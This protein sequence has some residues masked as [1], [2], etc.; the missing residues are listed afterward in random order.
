MEESNAALE[1][2]RS[3]LESLRTE[4]LEGA[5]AVPHTSPVP[6]TAPGPAADKLQARIAAL[7]REN[8]TQRDQF[9][10][11]IGE[12]EALV[13]ARIFKEEELE[14]EM[15]RLRAERDEARAGR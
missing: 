5:V 12:L 3:E 7:E 4:R 1:R 8:A 13:E 11:D 14:N 6:S 2:E 9:Q 10:R 15:E